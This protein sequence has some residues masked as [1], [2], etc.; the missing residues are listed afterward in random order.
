[1]AE[2]VKRY[3]QDCKTCNSTKAA[4][5]KPYGLLQSLPAL[6]EPWRD[7]T[8]D[9]IT[10][11]PLS[12]GVDRKAYDAILVVIECYTKLAKYYPV[13]KSITAEQFGNL[14]GH[15][16]F[17]SFDVPSSIVSN[18]GSIFTSTFWL[19][20]CHYLC[21][22]RCLTMTF[23]PHTNSQTESQNQMLKQYLHAYMNYQ[24]DDWARFL[25]MAEYAYNNAVNASTS[26]RP[27]KA[28]MGYNPDFNI[29]IFQEPEPAS[30]NAPKRI[31][32]L[33]ALRR[34]LQASWEQARNAQKKYYNKKHL[35][36]SFDI[37]I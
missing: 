14:F 19:A 9:F 12:L 24:Q 31:E 27:F 6:N 21:I 13:L 34:Q 25:L 29:E 1:M 32:E 30:Q 37:G 11:V 4:R 3:I 8:I 26:L 2:V 5:H 7:I 16:V 22:K 15:T 10:G 18:Q 20:L 35:K 23:Y 28:L 36:K 33:D 17:C